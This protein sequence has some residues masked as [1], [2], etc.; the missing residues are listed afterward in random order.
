MNHPVGNHQHMRDIEVAEHLT[1][2]ENRALAHQCLTRSVKVEQTTGRE[3]VYRA[4]DDV[5]NQRVIQ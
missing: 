1:N 5:L 3:F 4:G 2:S